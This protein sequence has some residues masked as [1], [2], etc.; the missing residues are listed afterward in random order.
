[1]GI[2]LSS[3]LAG[4]AFGALCLAP[5]ADRIGR[6]KLTL[7]GLAVASSRSTRTTGAGA[8]PSL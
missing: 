5:L 6:R 3:G 7:A 1:M 2:L 4:M 8:C